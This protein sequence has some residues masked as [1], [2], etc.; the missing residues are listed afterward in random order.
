MMEG[1]QNRMRGEA[2]RANSRRALV[3]LGIVSGY[4]PDRYAAKVRIQPEDFETGW[5]P[6]STPWSGDGWG[7]FCPPSPGDVAEVHFQ[8]GGKEAGFVALRHFGDAL[9][10]LPAP[11][12]EFWLVHASGSLVRLANDGR[13]TLNGALEIDATAPTVNIAATTRVNLT[14]PEIRLGGEGETFRRLVNDALVGLYNTHTHPD[15]DGGN[16]GIPNQ[17]MDADLLTTV[18]YAG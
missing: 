2:E 7:L 9:R 4:D 5:L 6:I 3:R 17:P 14:A 16:T 1:L 12:G 8:E 11:S 10:P 15:A 18:T 13:L